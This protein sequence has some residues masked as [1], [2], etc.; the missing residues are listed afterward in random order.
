MA[1]FGNDL[2]AHPF[3]GDVEAIRAEATQRLYSRILASPLPQASQGAAG[4]RAARRAA[5]C[6]LPHLGAGLPR[7]GM[8]CPPVSALL[9]LLVSLT[10]SRLT[11]RCPRPR[12]QGP[13]PYVGE[14]IFDYL[15]HHGHWQTAHAVN[16]DVLGGSMEVRR[17][18]GAPPP[19]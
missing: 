16:R 4:G 17:G 12:L 19:P 13:A 10:A 9:T 6:Q 5:G 7:G 15:K 11:A 2:A 8:V 3:K 18:P 1:N 14:L